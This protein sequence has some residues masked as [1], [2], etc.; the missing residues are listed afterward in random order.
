M[1]VENFIEIGQAL[2]IQQFFSEKCTRLKM[3]SKTIPSILFDFQ[4]FFK[5]KISHKFVFHTFV[6]HLV[7]TIFI[8]IFEYVKRRIKLLKLW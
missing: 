8:M 5:V 7:F 1:N 3:L 2:F 6:A 4:T